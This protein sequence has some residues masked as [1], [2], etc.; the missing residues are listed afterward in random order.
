MITLDFEGRARINHIRF[1]QD[2]GSWGEPVD[3]RE[4]A[5]REVS[6]LCPSVSPDGKAFFYLASP[7]GENIVCWSSAKFIEELKKLA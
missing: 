6:G 7:W 4:A 5:G 3:I 1:R 2:D